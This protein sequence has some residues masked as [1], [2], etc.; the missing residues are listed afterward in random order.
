[1][2]CFPYHNVY[3]ANRDLP[4]GVLTLPKIT[5]AQ[6]Q[7]R[8]FTYLADEAKSVAGRFQIPLQHSPFR[9]QCLW[10]NL[11]KS[12]IVSENKGESTKAKQRISADRSRFSR[13]S[14]A[15]R[16]L[17]RIAVPCKCVLPQMLYPAKNKKG[18]QSLEALI[19]GGGEYRNRTGHLLHAMQAPIGYHL[20]PLPIK[21]P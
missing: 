21:S 17:F 3:L 20:L 8:V 14:F 5:N 12:K 19:L 6:E 4:A 9:T 15:G 16:C 13:K 11:K 7:S 10:K 1:M 2:L 18:F